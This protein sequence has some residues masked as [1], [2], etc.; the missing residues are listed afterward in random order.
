[1]Q[2][3]SCQTKWQNG[4]HKRNSQIPFKQDYGNSREGTLV[5]ELIGG[6]KHKVYVMWNSPFCCE[7]VLLTLVNKEA[8]FTYDRTE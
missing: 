1:M 6:F 5:W 8:A 4:D 7:Y 2:G 3:Y